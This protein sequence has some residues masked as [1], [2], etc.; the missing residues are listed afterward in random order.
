MPTL[1]QVGAYRVVIFV[2]DHSPAHVHVIG[3]GGFAKVQLGDTPADVALVETMGISR[4][5]LRRVVG[6][7]IARHAECRNVWSKIHGN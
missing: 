7:I 3:A 6:E 4:V 1:F 2:N 5:R